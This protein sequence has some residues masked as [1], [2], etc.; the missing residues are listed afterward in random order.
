MRVLSYAKH[1][2]LNI[3]FVT[4]R[5]VNTFIVL[6][7]KK[8]S[9]EQQTQQILIFGYMEFLKNLKFL[10][11]KINNFGFKNYSQFEEDGII[12]FLLT[13]VGMTTKKV[14]EIGSGFGIENMSSNLIINHGYEGYLFDGSKKNVRT[15][16]SFYRSKPSLSLN[17]PVVTHA[18][19]NVENVNRVLEE[20][21]VKDEIDLLSIDV[22]GNDLYIWEAIE[23]IRPRV[24]VF[25]SQNAIPA[26]LSLS[27]PYEPDFNLMKNDHKFKSFHSASV[28]AFVKISARKGYRIVGA[29]NLGFNIFF[30]REDLCLDLFKSIEITDIH[31]N[32]YSKLKQ[33]Q[34]QEIKSLNWV[35]I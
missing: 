20:S 24:C 22:D 15:S 16:K 3:Y 14:V 9:L 28:D 12:L 32:K 17:L 7:T 2:L 25:E 27:I 34:W 21:G 10:N 1:F 11:C 35:E 29:N 33:N 26:G 31:N 4:I 6:N 18:F 19:I 5:I 30:V 23:I 8:D 13:A